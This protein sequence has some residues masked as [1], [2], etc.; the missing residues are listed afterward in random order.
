MWWFCEMSFDGAP[1]LILKAYRTEEEAKQAGYR[2][3]AGQ[4]V[5][6]VP[7][8][9]RNKRDVFSEWKASQ[10]YSQNNQPAY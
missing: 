8:D 7:F 2:Q 6:A 9:T 1:T 4:F 3:V 10:Q 5:R